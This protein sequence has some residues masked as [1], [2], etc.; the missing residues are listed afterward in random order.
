MTL[1]NVGQDSMFGIVHY[2]SR[3]IYNNPKYQIKTFF[4]KL[5]ITFNLDLQFL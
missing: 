2:D 4:I 5:K 1:K 3:N